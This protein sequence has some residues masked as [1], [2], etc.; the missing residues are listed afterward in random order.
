MRVAIVK[1]DMQAE[2]VWATPI[3][4]QEDAEQAEQAMQAKQVKQTSTASSKASQASRPP[5]SSVTRKSPGHHWK[6]Q[7]R[8]KQAKP[9]TQATQRRVI[10]VV[11]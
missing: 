3:H 8:A 4:G 2:N 1:S 9:A 7:S 11:F 5:P 10:D 6:Q